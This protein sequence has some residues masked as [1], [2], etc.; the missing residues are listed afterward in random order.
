MSQTIYTFGELKKVLSEEKN[1]FKPKLGDG[2]TSGN[3]KINADAIN[4][5]RKDV[6]SLDKDFEDK[7]DA[8]P[9]P[10]NAKLYTPSENGDIN[11]TLLDLNY[12]T[13]PDKEYIKRVES[14]VKGYPSV[15]NEKTT[16]LDKDSNPVSGN[17]RFLKGMKQ[18]NND[19]QK[20][21]SDKKHSGLTSKE[22]PKG[23]YKQNTVFKNESTMNRLYFKNTTFLNEAQMIKKIPEDYKVN[24]KRFYMKDKSENEYLVEWISNEERQINE[25]AILSY[26]NKNKINEDLQRIN[27]LFNYNSKTYFNATNQQTRLNEDKNHSVFL[28]KVKVLTEESKKKTN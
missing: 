15:E 14:Q 5:I 16:D 3:K 19:S 20:E 6:K 1:E 2:V 11:K 18:R 23:D 9:M 25:C 7:S 4:Q 26:S 8:T 21:I 12:T 24:G 22:L 10:K 17:E 28:N 13:P 27:N